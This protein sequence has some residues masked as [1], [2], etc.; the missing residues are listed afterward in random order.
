[1]P[2][3]YE[4]QRSTSCGTS[5][6]LR[7]NL[8]AS[9]LVAISAHATGTESSAM[10]GNRA[11]DAYSLSVPSWMPFVG[12]GEANAANASGGASETSIVRLVP[13]S[14]PTP[15]MNDTWDH[16]LGD[17]SCRTWD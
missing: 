2:H 17:R 13:G 4:S 7:W 3:P 9:R 10:F 14:F 15:G 6:V 8:S 11:A 5:S 16:A 12:G 1:M